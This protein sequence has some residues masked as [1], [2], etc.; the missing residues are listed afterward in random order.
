MEAR[1]RVLDWVGFYSVPTLV[2]ANPG[3]VLPYEEPEALERGLSPRGIDRGSMLT[4]PGASQLKQWLTHHA[5][6]AVEG[7]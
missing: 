3:E 1:Q 2:I 5:F 7:V 4:E 6:I